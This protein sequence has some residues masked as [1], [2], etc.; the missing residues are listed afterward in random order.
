MYYFAI[1]LYYSAKIGVFLSKHELFFSFRTILQIMEEK[2]IEKAT[3]FTLRSGKL[4]IYETNCSCKDIQFYFENYVLTLMYSGHKTIVSENLQFEF[5]PGTFFIPEKGVV[6][7]VSIPNA[8]FHNPTKCLVLELNP[9]FIQSVYREVESS[10]NDSH[11]LYVNEHPSPETYFLSNDSLL[12]DSFIQLYQLQSK[13]KSPVK[14]MIEDLILKEMLYRLFYTD[15]LRLLK[16]NFQ[17]TYDDSRI[18]RSVNYIH[19][20]IHQKISIASLA[21]IA[22][23]GHTSFFKRFKKETGFS[24]IDFVLNERIKKAK[25]LLHKDRWTLKEIA[26]RCGFNSYEYFC[27]SFKKI[28]NKKPSEFRKEQKLRISI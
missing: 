25:M 20:N 28:E 1:L 23:M 10:S 8:T 2:F 5:F 26:F 19:E 18:L 11:I 27:N 13:D 3:H 16:A 14:H 15:G 6:N 22:G 21:D 7:S 4:S 17:R 9:S 24:P 12:I